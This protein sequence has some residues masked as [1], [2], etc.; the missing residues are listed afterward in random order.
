MKSTFIIDF[1]DLTG[2]GIE[3]IIRIQIGDGGVE[4]KLLKMLLQSTDVLHI[5]YEN[6]GASETIN[7]DVM[8]S[9]SQMVHGKYIDKEE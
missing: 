5:C 8:L 3:P 4:D 2:N 6:S 9:K 7:R 1:A